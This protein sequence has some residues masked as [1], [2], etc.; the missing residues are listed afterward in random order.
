MKDTL[1]KT[2]IFRDTSLV[3]GADNS[4]HALDIID[5]EN[6]Y[7]L[8]ANSIDILTVNDTTFIIELSY[9]DFLTKIIT[10][11]TWSHVKYI[12]KHDRYELYV[13]TNLPTDTTL[14]DANIVGG[15]VTISSIVNDSNILFTDIHTINSKN[16]YIL[17]TYTVPSGKKFRLVAWQVNL[18]HPLACDISLQV[19]GITKIKFYLDPSQGKSSEYLYTAPVL[20]GN[21]NDIITIIIYPSAPRGEINS[22]LVGIES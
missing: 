18:D 6:N 17:R 1:F 3:L 11:L 14:I 21:S 19:N 7:Q 15:N 20:F 4:Q 2:T 22:I 8:L 10:P 16:E 5:F 12:T 13:L 9:S